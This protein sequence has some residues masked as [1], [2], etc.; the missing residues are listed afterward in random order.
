MSQPTSLVEIY[1][2]ADRRLKDRIVNVL[3]RRRYLEVR[4]ADQ[5]DQ[6]FVI[7]NC[8]RP[9]RAHTIFNKVTAIDPGAVLLRASASV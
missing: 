9:S 5:D 1:G 2:L 6:A 4:T 7:V 3:Q 8:R